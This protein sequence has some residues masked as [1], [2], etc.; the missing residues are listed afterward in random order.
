MTTT[1]TTQIRIDSKRSLRRTQEQNTKESQGFDQCQTPIYALDPLLPFLPKD[2]I[3]W[4]SAC[5]EGNL[6]RGLS[7]MGYKVMATDILSGSN[8]FAFQPALWDC[9]VTNP[10]Y[11]IKLDW[12]ERSF[13]LCKPFALLLPVELL[14]VGAAQKM[15]KKSDM[16]IILINKRVNFQTTRTSFSKSNAWFPVCWM[17]WGLNIGQQLTFGTILKRP[18]EQMQLFQEAAL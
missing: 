12:L 13:Q 18:N 10:P 6:S 15:F 3:L 16:E 1:T 8:F 4:E 5:G 9:Q 11:S 7:D 2:W 14:G 17:T